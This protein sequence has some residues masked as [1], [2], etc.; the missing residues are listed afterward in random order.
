MTNI[1]PYH[2]AESEER[3]QRHTT[4]L[5]WLAMALV[6]VISAVVLYGNYHGWFQSLPEQPLSLPGW[7]AGF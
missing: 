6:G 2:T 4:V 1:H 7:S 5:L 3:W